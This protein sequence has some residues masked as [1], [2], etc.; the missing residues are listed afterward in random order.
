[1]IGIGREHL[2]QFRGVLVGDGVGL[3]ER[4]VPP[5]IFPEFFI[6]TTLGRRR[7]DGRRVFIMF[8]GQL[9]RR[10]QESLRDLAALVSDLGDIYKT[11]R[12]KRTAAAAAPA[13]AFVASSG[14][15]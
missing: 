8:F 10:S 2:E 1:L 15:S 4:R 3:E 7:D 6:L 14:S 12:I 13:A 5:D 9:Y 11:G